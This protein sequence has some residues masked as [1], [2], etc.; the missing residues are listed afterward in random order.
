MRAC[1]VSFFRGTHPA[2]RQHADDE[3]NK[4]SG[5]GGIYG[6]GV[7][8][9][10]EVI[11]H[12]Q[13]REKDR[14]QPRPRAANPRAGHD[15]GEEQKQKGVREIACCKIRV[16]KQRNAYKAAARF[17]SVAAC[18]SFAWRPI[19]LRRGAEDT[20]R[21]SRRSWPPPFLV[22]SF[23]ACSGIRRGTN[24]K[25]RSLRFEKLISSMQDGRRLFE[26]V[27]VAEERENY[28]GRKSSLCVTNSG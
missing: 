22:Y 11:I 25:N 23:L 8:W 2:R 5:V 21:Y 17:H 28:R 18:L 15:S 10:N 20:S 3:G 16:G 26:G 1:S 24:S 14:E 19:G 7:K 4:I 6:E 27:Q 9:G 13:C 12:S